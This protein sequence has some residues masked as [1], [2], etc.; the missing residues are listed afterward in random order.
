[1][2]TA[3]TEAPR[4]ATL[5]QWAKNRLHYITLPSNTV[6]GIEIPDIAE[7]CRAGDIPNHLID[8]ALAAANG[9]KITRE[10]LEQQAEFTAHLIP[11]VVKEPKVTPEDVSKLPPEDKDMIIGIATRQYDFDALGHH[12]GG[13]HKVSDF[14][15]FRGLPLLDEDL[16]DV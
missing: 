10:H 12:I 3:A 9:A 7:L 16:E 6:V 15:R 8:A 1:M 2:S 4:A 5:S 13:L 11:L 14:R